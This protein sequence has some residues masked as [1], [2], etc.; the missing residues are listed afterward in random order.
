M[1]GVEC[2]L[3]MCSI[4]DRLVMPLYVIV[5]FLLRSLW[6]VGRREGGGLS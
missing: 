5:S 4:R 3:G 1:W 6:W 2:G